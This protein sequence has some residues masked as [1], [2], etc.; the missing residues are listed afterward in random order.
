M[1]WIFAS[2]LFFFSVSAAAE[3]ATLRLLDGSTVVGEVRSLDNGVYQVE[4][5]SLGPIKIPQVNVRSIQY[6]DAAVAAAG[7]LLSAQPALDVDALGM[8]MMENPAILSIL[9]S[10]K[11]DPQFQSVITDPEIQRAINAGDY[12]SL[13]ANPK[14]LELM[15]HSMVKAIAGELQP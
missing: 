9:Q 15:N 7:G 3:T 1:Q 4:A 11:S 14:I 13:M 6:G 8:L 2:L 5:D 12:L 10:L